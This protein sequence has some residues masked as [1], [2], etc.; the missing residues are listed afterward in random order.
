MC[1]HQSVENELHVLTK[2][3]AYN[4]LRNN[5]YA[6]L[7]DNIHFSNLN[8]DHK[9]LWLMTNEAP[10]VCKNLAKYVNQ[11]FCIRYEKCQGNFDG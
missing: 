7:S 3:P 5:L 8:D 1:N 6:T 9:F 2:C 11:A 4:D 10:D